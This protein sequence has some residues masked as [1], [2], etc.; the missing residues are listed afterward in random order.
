MSSRA[1]SNNFKTIKATTATSAES[2]RT[3]FFPVWKWR[4]QLRY[5]ADV[6]ITCFC[7]GSGSN[8]SKENTP[9][10]SYW[11][12]LYFKSVPLA[13]LI[14]LLISIRTKEVACWILYGTSFQILPFSVCI[15]N[16]SQRCFWCIA[17]LHCWIDVRMSVTWSYFG[18]AFQSNS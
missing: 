3:S 17:N 7:N 8:W 5:I 11:S 2:K 13:L 18:S 15:L 4:A 12:L 6:W 14:R 16:L 1:L 9:L 10:T